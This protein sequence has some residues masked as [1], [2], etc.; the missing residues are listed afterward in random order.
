MLGQSGSE[1]AFD[2]G[3]AVFLALF[4]VLVVSIVRY[5]RRLGREGRKPR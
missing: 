2:I 1:M 3:F 4:I 5:T